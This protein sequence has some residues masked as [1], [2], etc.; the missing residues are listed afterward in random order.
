MF[1]SWGLPSL[2]T[3]IGA[4]FSLVTVAL[5]L[6]LFE[7]RRLQTS[8]TV[9]RDTPPD[10]SEDWWGPKSRLEWGEVDLVIKNSTAGVIRGGL[11][12]AVAVAI[13]SIPPFVGFAV[14]VLVVELD[15]AAF[16]IGQVDQLGEVLFSVQLLVLTFTF[17]ACF[18]AI[19]F[20]AVHVFF[21]GALRRQVKCVL[22]SRGGVM[23]IH[24][25]N[26]R[27][28]VDVV[29]LEASEITAV[30][31]T[32]HPSWAGPPSDAF[33][34]AG[35]D[36]LRVPLHGNAGLLCELLG[37]ELRKT[38]PNLADL[39][40]KQGDMSGSRPREALQDADFEGYR[41][42]KRPYGAFFLS[43]FVWSFI[44]ILSGFLGF[45]LGSDSGALLATGL[46]LWVIWRMFSWSFRRPVLRVLH[47]K[48][49]LVV[50]GVSFG[51][52]GP[53]EG[54]PIAEASHIVVGGERPPS[55]TNREWFTLVG[56]NSRGGEWGPAWEYD[57]EYLLPQRARGG[58]VVEEGSVA[59]GIAMGIA[60]AIGIP[61]VTRPYEKMKFQQ[62]KEEA[63]G[64]G[65]EVG[66]RKADLVARL[67][68][69]DAMARQG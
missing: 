40:V 16:M 50:E 45:A 3:L 36:V 32:T 63:R 24:Y 56:V 1:F 47:T 62:L 53:R 65:L 5:V 31:Q 17:L 19:P 52:V 25:V 60:D 66:R 28:L 41:D 57:L 55:G 26:W 10:D 48:G 23:D 49:S 44:L 15:I 69:S 14:L 34:I 2:S 11:L 21:A 13:M 67:Y 6:L 54:W 18:L 9:E 4:F 30:H 29:H 42:R 43:T 39:Y 51:R 20:Y 7:D 61:I 33:I 38:E 58:D 8:D 37:L 64:R 59:M 12:L 22:A 46:G 27:G 35:W 68:E